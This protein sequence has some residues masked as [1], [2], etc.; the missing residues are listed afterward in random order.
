MTTS[1]DSPDD[2]TDAFIEKRNIVLVGHAVSTDIEYLRK[3]GY[4]V[5]NLS[6]VLEA[7]DTANLYC[8][9]Q[10][11]QQTTKLGSVLL[12]LGLTG[13]NL[14]NA[15]NDAAYTLQ[16][17]VGVAIENLATRKERNTSH[18]SEEAVLANTLEL[19]AR[20][21]AKDIMEEWATADVEGGD[22]GEPVSLQKHCYS[23]DTLDLK[24]QTNRKQAV[25]LQ[26]ENK[27]AEIAGNSPASRAALTPSAKES[28]REEI[29]TDV[30][31]DIALAVSD[32]NLPRDTWMHTRPTSVG[33][34]NPYPPDVLARLALLE[35]NNED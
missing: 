8:A 30:K 31:D 5:A 6:N 13:W 16:A 11:E 9:W 3:V 28:K 26:K 33:G 34:M 25:V 20:E 29:K 4:D 10:H 2:N 24:T 22:G 21:Q 14:H 32:P 18:Q 19:Q 27:V 1:A 23:W 35:Q 7:V 12:S 15:G 17:M